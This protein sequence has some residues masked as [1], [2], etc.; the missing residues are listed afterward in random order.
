MPSC[1]VL[2]D[3]AAAASF[4][5]NH[6]TI[7]VFGEKQFHLPGWEMAPE[8]WSLQLGEVQ[9]CQAPFLPHS[10]PEAGKTF[11]QRKQTRASKAKGGKDT[12]SVTSP[13]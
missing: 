10:L 11:G 12:K 8:C 9:P 7:W 1:W 5:S 4:S 13:A 6:R 2:Q 3:S